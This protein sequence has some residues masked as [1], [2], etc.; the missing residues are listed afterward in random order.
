MQ[1]SLIVTVLNEGESIRRLMDSICAQTRP[2]DE[3]VI[4]DGGSTDDTVA[5]LE[6]YADRLPLRMITRPGA[7]IAAGRNAA[8]A[9]ASHDALAVTDAGVR[10]DPDW[11]ARIVA[12][13]EADPDTHVAAGFFV[14]DPRTPFE[15]AMG[16]TVLPERRD[17]D[18]KTFLPSS[19]SAA[20]RRRAV[21]G[22]GGYPEWI[23]FCEDLILDFRLRAR[24]GPFAFAPDAVVHFRP[25]RSL[26]AF[27]KQ[28][29]QYAR[30]DGKANLFFRRHLI[31]YLTYLAAL[32]LIVAA[33]ALFSAW[34]LLL[35][36]AGGGYMVWTP[37][38]RL[39]NQWSGLPVGQK[40]AAV[41]WVPI[42]R[43][44]G[45]LAKMAGYPAGLVWRWRHNPPDWR[46]TPTR[47][48]DAAR[49]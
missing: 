22:I 14:P 40:I 41:I 29:Y 35:L 4:C 24:Y 47:R 2:P 5:I 20:F 13:L 3:V 17:I 49:T 44:A 31:R 19:R 26:G 25:R 46:I 21:E 8:I 30:G 7:N 43:V 11:L 6:S 32:P 23:D 45:D 1:I 18:P 16:A 10:L 38:R 9:A 36:L 34:W 33:G 39:L 28:Y 37:Y 48:R 42:I 15:V 12:P 27:L